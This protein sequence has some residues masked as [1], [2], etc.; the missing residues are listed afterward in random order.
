VYSSFTRYGRSSSWCKSHALSFRALSRAVSI[1]SQLKKYMQ[2]FGLP[3]ES[4]QG[5]AKR[6]RQCLV[7]GYWRNG[8]RWMADGTFRSVR[9]NKVLPFHLRW[10]KVLMAPSDFIYS[11]N[12][13]FV[14]PKTTNRMGH[15]PWNGRNQKDTDTYHYWDRG[16]LVW[17]VASLSTSLSKPAII[18][19]STMATSTS[20]STLAREYKRASPFAPNELSKILLTFSY[21]G[22]CMAGLPHREDVL[23][24]NYNSLT[25]T[26]LH[27][28]S[29]TWELPHVC[30]KS[31]VPNKKCGMQLG[32]RS[33]CLSQKLASPVSLLAIN[34]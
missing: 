23:W 5:D 16:G 13:S 33:S 24:P 26:L 31:T 18:G 27:K 14:Y 12:L 28:V 19:Y 9:G 17:S 2:R 22:L 4:C 32:H 6:V 10:F 21:I 3:L 30:Q 1:R 8:A 7:S 20:T 29:Q 15:I 25:V 34:L 11:S